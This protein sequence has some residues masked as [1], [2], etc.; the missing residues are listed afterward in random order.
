M[1]AA[2]SEV[3]QSLEESVSSEE[4]VKLGKERLYHVDCFKSRYRQVDILRSLDYYC[5]E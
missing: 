2:L 5:T 4:S 3:D 1:A